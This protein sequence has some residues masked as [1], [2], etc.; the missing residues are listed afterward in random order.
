MTY[1]KMIYLKDLIMLKKIFYIAMFSS[2][3]FLIYNLVVNGWVL[4]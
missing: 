4:L 3:A 1:F 2:G